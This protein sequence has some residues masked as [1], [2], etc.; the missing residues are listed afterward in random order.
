[1]EKKINLLKI[2]ILLLAI[3][4]FYC[5]YIIINQKNELNALRN[6]KKYKS[7]F[8]AI[9]DKNIEEVRNFINK[10][11]DINERSTMGI[12]PL[13]KAVIVGD[14]RA[15]E[16]L[17]SAGA[18]IEE[19][20]TR[21]N[22][23]ALHIAASR[24]ELEIAGILVKNGADVDA[25]RGSYLLIMD[26]I[27]DWDKFITSLKKHDNPA[28]DRIWKLLDEDSEKVIMSWK[29]GDEHYKSAK[30][31]VITGI[32]RVLKMD[33]FYSPSA[34]KDVTLDSQCVK[35]LNMFLK[36]PGKVNPE[37]VNRALIESIY[38]EII[39]K[40][41]RKSTPLH[42][43]VL[44]KHIDVAKFLL[45][46]GAEIDARD[47]DGETA[48]GV[49]ADDGNVRIARLLVSRG[50]NINVKN[51]CG[52]TP[53]TEASEEGNLD[54]VKLLI[55]SGANINSLDEHGYTPLHRAAEKGRK[56]IVEFLVSKGADVDIK[57]KD[58]RTP[59][60][61][62]LDNGHKEIW[63][64]LSKHDSSP[65]RPQRKNGEQRQEDGGRNPL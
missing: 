64:I 62:A 26:D 21:E 52:D 57:A 1:M 30:F 5:I 59:A 42:E 55:S 23:T 43:A 38:P 13:H 14:K 33:D 37:K 10:G 44:N 27:L 9:N 65:Q 7:I 2:L 31:T 46:K 39:K 54:V 17:L 8:N 4:L 45:D 48:L 58:G 32:N 41:T 15:V 47:E 60:K 29:P 24:G 22:A 61:M 53:L 28:V 6:K 63:E 50:A 11:A 19:K 51:S 35:C 16:L 34:F 12:T 40:C 56:E 49:A 36:N 3:A 20:N 18:S 25:V